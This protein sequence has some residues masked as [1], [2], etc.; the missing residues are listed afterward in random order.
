MLT[1]KRRIN[2]TI[3]IGNDIVLKV[4]GLSAYAVD[5]TI[6]APN[7]T[8]LEPSGYVRTGG[9]GRKSVRIRRRRLEEVTINGIIEVS[10]YDVTKTVVSLG[11]TAPESIRIDRGDRVVK[12]GTQAEGCGQKGEAA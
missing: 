9:P 12:P 5:M 2:Q 7:R 1:L 10:V 6:E 3:L 11:I 8:S 4:T